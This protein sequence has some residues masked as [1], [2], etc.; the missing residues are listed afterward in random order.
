MI[1]RET[2]LWTE[3]IKIGVIVIGAFGVAVGLNFFLIPAD[4]FAS[5]MTGIAQILAALLPLSAGILLFALNIPVAILGWKK[6]GRLFTFY[7]F[8]HV[9]LTTF[10]LEVLPIYEISEDILLNAVFGGVI[11]AAGAALPLKY[12][13]SA[14]GLDII[15]LVLARMSDRPV[16]T[17]FFLLNAMIVLAAGALFDLEEALYTLVA[18][19]VTSRVIDA[20][21]TRHVK[22]TAMIVTKNADEVREAVHEHITRGITRMPAK[23]GY[24]ANDKEVLMIV[25]TRYELYTLKQII[26]EVDPEA[27]TNVMN[28]SGI[29]G[30][31]R[32]DS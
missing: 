28:T 18:I 20:I 24:D 16:G 5:G 12:G 4:V 3:L 15:A 11:S 13:A 21:H 31:F 14:G 10:F 2:T 30:T 8:M 27:F 7:S 25:I 26:E 22:L 32:K 17:Y 9:A 1:T 23:G 29:F 6:V 19:Y